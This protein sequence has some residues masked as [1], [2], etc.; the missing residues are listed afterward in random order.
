MLWKFWESAKGRK[1]KSKKPEPAEKIRRKARLDLETLER[2]WLF[3]TS[4]WLPRAPIVVGAAAN[5]NQDPF[6][7]PLSPL[8]NPQYAV[9]GNVS[10]S[11]S[12][13]GPFTFDETGVYT[14]SIH[15]TGSNATNSITFDD[16]GTSTFTL[17]EGGNLNNGLF[18]FN[19]YSLTQN[20]VASWQFVET[21]LLGQVVQNS[22]GTDTLSLTDTSPGIS[23]YFHWYGYNW[24]NLVN[25][26]SNQHNL[27]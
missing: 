21:T 4:P 25:S 3:S 14:F 5:F 6:F 18:S 23:D 11:L 1:R 13:A 26:T 20:A 15:M 10:A 24:Y 9:G 7:G 8:L 16:S 2:R 19:S 22:S 12:V 17:H 27:G